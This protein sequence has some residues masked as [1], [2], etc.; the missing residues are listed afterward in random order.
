MTA[1]C[2]CFEPLFSAVG[3]ILKLFSAVGPILKLSIAATAAA[4]TIEGGSIGTT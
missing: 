2:Q 3:P 1:D 4:V